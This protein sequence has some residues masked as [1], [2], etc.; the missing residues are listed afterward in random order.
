MEKPE[1][2]KLYK[3]YDVA[4]L[5]AAIYKTMGRGFF[6]TGLHRIL[7]II[8]IEFMKKYDYPCFSDEMTAWD[9]GPVVA[10]QFNEILFLESGSKKKDQDFSNFKMEHI[11]LIKNVIDNI[12]K[13]D[14]TEFRGFITGQQSFIDAFGSD[15]KII[16]PSDVTK[17]INYKV[18]TKVIVPG[19]YNHL[20]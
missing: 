18:K 14:M 4:K 17:D 11:L 7:Y 9:Y 2:I 10:D 6:G 8:Q 20:N 19:K 12:C 16:L 13:M 1:N 5:V 3:A 15:N